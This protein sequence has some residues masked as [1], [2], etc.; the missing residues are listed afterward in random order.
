[1]Y[2]VYIRLQRPPLRRWLH[3]H[4]SPRM[5][6][7]KTTYSVELL[8]LRRPLLLRNVITGTQRNV[9]LPRRYV[10][11]HNQGPSV[12]S[13][14]DRLRQAWRSIPPGSGSKPGPFL[15]DRLQR[16]GTFGYYHNVL[17]ALLNALRQG[18]T[19]KLYF[20][21]MRFVRGQDHGPDASWCFAEVVASIPPT[22]FSEILRCFDPYNVS[23]EIDTAPG[24]NISYGAALHTPLGELV[25][26]W[27]VKLLYVRIF[28]RLRRMQEARRHAR[29]RPLLNDCVV[30]MRCAAAT[31]D[32][33]AAKDIWHAMKDDGFSTWRHTEAF[34]EFVKAR[35]LTERL[36]ANNDLARLR[37]RPLDMHRSSLNF[38]SHV[39]HRLRN[40]ELNMTN[41]RRHRFGEN[42]HERYFAEPLTRLLRRRKPVRRLWHTAKLRGMLSGDERLLCALLKANGRCGR[43]VGSNSVLKN[44][45]G[46]WI[47]RDKAS[48]TIQVDGGIIYP[49]DSPRAPTEHLLDAI[50]HC[51]CCMGEINMAVKL[52]DF[53]SRRFGIS[54][55][56]KVWSDLLE[57]TRIMQT[58]PAA[59]E[60]AIARF[61]QK[62]S[63][64]NTVL[65][66][67]DLCT[68][69]PYNFQPGMR[70]YYNLLKS[71]VRKSGSVRKPIQALRQIKPLYDDAVRA[72]EEAWCELMQTTIQRVPNHAAYRRYRV[73][74]A[75]KDHIW[76]CF[77]YSSRQILKMIIPNRVDDDGGVREIPN[78]VREFGQFMPRRVKY[79]VATGYVEY[80]S[81]NNFR[82][83]LVEA[84]Q[85]VEEPL[86]ISQRPRLVE[87]QRDQE[88]WLEDI[89]DEGYWDGVEDHTPSSQDDM[90][91]E[92]VDAHGPEHMSRISTSQQVAEDT[93]PNLD[94]ETSP[95]LFSGTE[96]DSLDGDQRQ[97]PPPFDIRNPRLGASRWITDTQVAEKPAYWF[98]PRHSGPSTQPSI[99]SIRQDG[100]EFTGYHDDDS[101]KHFAAH[102]VI[103]STKRVAAVPIDLG[104]RGLEKK[105]AAEKQDLPD[106]AKLAEQFL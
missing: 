104:L 35:Y 3:G 59:N 42:M 22:T 89:M 26:K 102:R 29:I 88:E 13:K 33:R 23:E 82:R 1:M 41:L 51:Y 100:G 34:G 60:W 37:L 91:K 39:A 65:D 9:D 10:H 66:V 85:V 92:E 90:Q 78:L 32:I 24:M 97:L 15:P 21:L 2:E 61:A 14:S 6:T 44:Y 93:A 54:V 52:V 27:G 69:E 40:L 80:A 43:L 57:Y 36:Y 8:L 84:Q 49:P 103:R 72:C 47:Q 31:S 101:L 30:L 105:G 20:C 63:K 96:E 56:D 28:N 62:G 79:Q 11:T 64:A 17:E 68:Q 94:Q 86:P 53:V 76:Y 77:H 75:R 45:W 99:I 81:D 4:E 46:I 55:P 87:E 95:E 5:I 106:T 48:G 70:D 73:L 18:D 58:K 19:L 7:C 74:R 71:I 67:W 12:W 16:P 50:V 83:N 98:R 38:R 25:N